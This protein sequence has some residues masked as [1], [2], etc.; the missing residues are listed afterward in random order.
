MKTENIYLIWAHPRAD[1]LT[2]RVVEEMQEQ[3][4]LDGNSTT[5]LD[6]YR[7]GF[8]PV[9]GTEDEPA[10]DDSTKRHSPEVHR[11]FAELQG[12]DTLVVVFPVWWYSFPAIIKGYMDRVWNHGLAY[13]DGHRLPAKK[14][15][16]VGLVG[17]SE[18][19]FARRG[20]LTNMTDFFNGIGG[21]LGIEDTKVTF[22]Y[23]TI[24][25]EEDIVDCDRHFQSLFA[26]ARGVVSGLAA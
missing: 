14:I 23:N 1:S 12:K 25:V 24:G 6:L 4:A 9:L 5:T 26:E 15:H 17:G 10:W 22:L 8:D 13:G 11:L 20:W 7:R 19:R 21:Y 2:A 3:A 18:E 16:W